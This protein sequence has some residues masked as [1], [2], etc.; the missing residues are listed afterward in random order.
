MGWIVMFCMQ[1]GTQVLDGVKFCHNCGALIAP[2]AAAQQQ[3]T[4][5][6]YTQPQQAMQPQPMQATPSPAPAG[7]LRC[8]SCGGANVSVQVVE[9][10]QMTTK[11]GVG[12]GGH[13]NNAARATTAVFTMG[14]SNIVW[15]KNKGTSKTATVNA[16]M[17]V[18]QSCGNTWTI[19]KGKFGSAPNSLFR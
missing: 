7:G 16:T 1:C 15:K 6:L 8:P 5:A 13:V 4:R 19:K 9:Q 2:M 18:C 17:G 11:K 12:F 3:P 14:L 10:G